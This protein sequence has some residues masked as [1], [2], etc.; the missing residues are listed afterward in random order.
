[1]KRFGI[2]MKINGGWVWSPD[3]IKYLRPDKK[4]RKSE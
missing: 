4:Y 2:G 1:M 3:E